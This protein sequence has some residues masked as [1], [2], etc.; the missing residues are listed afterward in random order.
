M[1][2]NFLQAV[3][4]F[5]SEIAPARLRGGL[6]IVFQ[7]MVTIGILIANIVNYFTSSIHPYGWR[8]ALG[9]AGIP[10]L[11]LLF[12][13][14]LICE[15]PT[16]LIER[17]KTK[18]GKETLKKIRGVE[19]VDEEYESI[20]HACDFARQVKD[21]YTKLMKPA[22]RP[23]FVIGMLLQFFQQFT[24]INA[25]MFYAPVLFQTVGFGNDAA[26]L[27]A[28]ITGTINVLSTFV[29]IFLVDKT[30][31]RFLLLQ[32]SVHMLVCQVIF[33]LFVSSPIS[34]LK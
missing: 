2:L 7:L 26:L 5:L 27:S 14:L 4:L 10:A 8:L 13:S 9:G 18:E 23:P 29:G 34:K 30:G 17:N 31:R 15:T 19:D 16:S 1:C 6:N 25:I 21:P 28:V 12:G 24:G 32:S 33:L 22:S 20:V 3:P 11:I